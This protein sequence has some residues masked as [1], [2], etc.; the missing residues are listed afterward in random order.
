M[1]SKVDGRLED[2]AHLGGVAHRCSPPLPKAL[3]A[4]YAETTAPITLVTRTF[5]QDAG[6][7]LDLW[8]VIPRGK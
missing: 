1:L 3:L 5:C 2:V 4:G 6:F 7:V 8:D